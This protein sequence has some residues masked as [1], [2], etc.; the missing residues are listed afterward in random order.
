MQ[1]GGG[2]KREAWDY[3]E[4]EEENDDEEFMALMSKVQVNP[5]M[6]KEAGEQFRQSAQHRQEHEDKEI[7]GIMDKV[8][9][10]MFEIKAVKSSKAA[11]SKMEVKASQS[12]VDSDEFNLY[13][14]SYCQCLKFMK[15]CLKHFL[16]HYRNGF[17][18]IICAYLLA[19]TLTL[20]KAYMIRDLESGEDIF[21]LGSESKI[22]MA[23][24]V[25]YLKKDLKSQ[26]RMVV[27]LR[28]VIENCRMP[29]HTFGILA[30]YLEEDISQVDYSKLHSFLFFLLS[31]L[32][33]G[34]REKS[35]H[36]MYVIDLM[37][38]LLHKNYEIVFFEDEFPNRWDQ[39]Y[40]DAKA[41][42]IETLVPHWSLE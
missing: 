30:P 13:F 2:A 34:R 42:L 7:K 14:A 32:L 28:N 8:Q 3:P 12:K 23:K 5:N 20:R 21:E 33:K 17:S 25:S 19:L 11:K 15:R 38:I 35:L 31:V 4:L 36:E 16:A 22:S 6:K 24:Y 40:F 37:Y 29:V 39:D 27:E 1:L 41:L 18:G 10:S 9:S 26:G